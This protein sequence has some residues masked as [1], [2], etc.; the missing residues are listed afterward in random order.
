MKPLLVPS[1]ALVLAAALT[2]SIRAAQSTLKPETHTFKKTGDV[3]IQADV[4]RPKSKTQARPPV[5]VWIHGGGLIMGGRQGIH[6]PLFEGLLHAGCAVISIDYRLAPQTKLPEII[7]DVED[8]FA[9]IRGEGGKSLGLD[10]TRVAVA[11]GSAGGYLTLVA[12]YRVTPR[13]K[14]LVSFW[15]YGEIIGPWYSEP[16]PHARHWKAKVSDDEAA[17]FLAGS[18]VANDADRPASGGSFYSYCRQRG[19]WPKFVSGWDPRTDAD[20]FIPYMPLRNVSPEYPPTL[21]IHGEDDTDVPY[22]QSRLMS[23]ELA[24]H[25]VPHELVSIPKAEHGLAGADA[26]TVAKVNAAALAFLKKHLSLG[27]EARRP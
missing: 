24:R 26:K 4:Y 19:L 11:G 13:P 17:A 8:A 3:A 7:R 18:P 15:G 9:W 14:A 22:E 5:V 25:K 12:G 23:L 27:G 2:P 21:L 20:P 1:I 10:T 16:S 6:R